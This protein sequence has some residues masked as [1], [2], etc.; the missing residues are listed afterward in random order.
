M[1][2][3][4][5]SQSPGFFLFLFFLSLVTI[6]AHIKMKNEHEIWH[7]LEYSPDAAEETMRDTAH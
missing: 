6:Q 7:C 3:L 2:K 1:V 4:P 5:H